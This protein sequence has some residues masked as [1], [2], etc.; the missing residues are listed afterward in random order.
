MGIGRKVRLLVDETR[1]DFYSDESTRRIPIS[2]FYPTKE[3]TSSFYE[4]VYH[5]LE[6]L[7]YKIYDEGKEGQRDYLAKVPVGFQNDAPVDLTCQRPVIVFSHGLQADRDFYLFLI[8]PLVREGYVVVTVGH[9]YDTDFTLIPGEPQEVVAMKK[10]LLDH[11]QVQYRKDQ[12]A[13]RGQDLRFV[14]D[15]LKD[16]NEMEEFKNL[17]DLCKVA[18]CGH[19]LGGM[20]VLK[21]LSHPLVKVGVMLDAALAYIDVEDALAQDLLV[22]KPL[23]NFRRDG[24]SYYDRL[25]H[26][27]EKLRDT[28]ANRFKDAI[29]KEHEATLG[30]MVATRQLFHYVAGSHENF[31]TM[32]KTVHMS[33]C[34]WFL[35]HPEKYYASLMP[36][37]EAHR[38]MV[39]LVSAF[40]EQHLLGR[41]KPY[42]DLIEQEGVQGVHLESFLG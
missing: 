22:P 28:Q 26:R 18:I 7:F 23:L 39:T 19:S 29:L 9:L 42:S 1:K 4:A 31:I 10:G 34:D 27:I 41:G 8:E 12:I 14:L 25:S 11:S 21:A 40:F 33:F 37:E 15:Q 16:F 2:I 38:G 3:E 35:L 5:P 24:I 36:I 30:E 20:T 32:D 13:A 6:E 17:L